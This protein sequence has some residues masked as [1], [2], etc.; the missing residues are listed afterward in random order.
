MQASD[1]EN[2]ASSSQQGLLTR[3]KSLLSAV[4]DKKFWKS[5]LKWIRPLQDEQAAVTDSPLITQTLQT[6]H[7]TGFHPFYLSLVGKHVT[8][9]KGD[10]FPY[11]KIRLKHRADKSLLFT[12][13]LLRTQKLSESRSEGTIT[14]PTSEVM[15]QLAESVLTDDFSLGLAYLLALDK[16][17]QVDE[18]FSN[19]GSSYLCFHMAAYCC[20]LHTYNTLAPW[21]ISHSRADVYRFLPS[22]LIDHIMYHVAAGVHTKWKN[23]C[24][25]WVNSLIRYHNRMADFAQGQL[26]RGLGKGVDIGRFAQDP[27][28]KRETILGLAMTIDEEV[29]ITAISLADR[30][31]ISKWEMLMTHLEC[32]F[33]DDNLSTKEIQE[34]VNKL[35]MMGTLLEDP[36]K[37]AERMQSNVYLTIDGT[38]H[39]RLIYYYMVLVYCGEKD[40][41]LKGQL[42]AETHL[43]TLKKIKP[44]APSL[45]YKKLISDDFPLK[46]LEPVMTN[47]NVHVLA[48]LANKIPTKEG[49]HIEPASVFRVFT[50]KLFWEGEQTSKQ[51]QARHRV[52][53]SKRYDA[54]HKMLPRLSPKGVQEFIDSVTFSESAVNNITAETR[55]AIVKRALKFARQ[56]DAALVKKG[57]IETQKNSAPEGMNSTDLIKHLEQSH[58][59]LDSLADPLIYELAE[60]DKERNTTYARA[61]DLSRSE[62]DKICKLASQMILGGVSL[63]TVNELYLLAARQ[64]PQ[65]GKVGKALQE[66]FKQVLECLSQSA[67]SCHLFLDRK[68]PM[69]VVKTII[70]TV[71][72]HV[73]RGGTMVNQEDIVECLKPFCAN[74][75]VSAAVKTDVLR[76]IEESFDLS[77]EDIFL[78]M[79]YQTDALVS[80]NWN[81]HLSPED[82]DSDTKRHELFEM[83]LKESLSLSQLLG[84]GTL[85]QIWPVL[86]ATELNEEPS[87]NPWVQL[88]DK[89]I[90]CHGDGEVVIKML[91]QL[92]STTSL[93]VECCCHVYNLMLLKCRSLYALKFAFVSKLEA[94]HHLALENMKNLKVDSNS[95]DDELLDLVIS[96][97]L[98]AE[99][100]QTPFLTP[101]VSYVLPEGSSD[102]TQQSDKETRVHLVASQLQLAGYWAEAGTLLLKYHG[103]HPALSTYDNSVRVL[104]RWLRR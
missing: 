38:K 94:M 36:A 92:N 55:L 76:T 66:T 49:V 96:R 23:E 56:Q 85:L 8:R 52:D 102:T 24:Q 2:G 21:M 13:C 3:P 35:E 54:C 41:S 99:I 19:F 93:T 10:G 97:G 39:A 15:I 63:E 26:L 28:Y 101:L 22:D 78:F 17:E 42:A 86:A 75:A 90:R 4:G 61:Y 30:Y 71:S 59:H 89:L 48:K 100:A 69:D 91:K 98:T 77:G 47:A 46:V 79:F 64:T 34:R 87:A 82:I 33:S 73:Q 12:H 6:L 67:E 7:A 70:H 103:T 25:P 32:L 16:A 5:T 1:Q 72:I 31:E 95:C 60:H 80:S 27:E 74:V 58:R 29:F 62:P 81:Q 43:K 14:E 65:M 44:A 11:E 57:A 83:L 88:M 104:S 53:W 9:S 68:D 40:N 45:D 50:E 84:L 51:E 37:V 18:F 20:A